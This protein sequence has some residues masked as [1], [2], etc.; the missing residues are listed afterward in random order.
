M[1]YFI[2]S[3]PISILTH[4]GSLGTRKLKYIKPKIIEIVIKWRTKLLVK[5]EY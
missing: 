1:A 5:R 3:Y 2:I 4:L